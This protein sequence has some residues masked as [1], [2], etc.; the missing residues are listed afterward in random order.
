[1]SVLISNE[2]GAIMQDGN[3]VNEVM[4]HIEDPIYYCLALQVNR[5]WKECVGLHAQRWCEALSFGPEDWERYFGE[6]GEVPKLP[7]SIFQILM[8]S[9][10][11]SEGQRVYETHLLTLIPETVNGELLTLNTLGEM[12]QHPRKG[13]QTQYKKYPDTIKKSLAIKG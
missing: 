13:H 2:R 4:S 9:C 6:V 10:P 7:P 3:V 8:Q 11:Y 12:I 5:L 1:M